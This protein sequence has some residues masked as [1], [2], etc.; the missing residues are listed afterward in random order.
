[1]RFYKNIVIFTGTIDYY[2]NRLY[3]DSVVSRGVEKFFRHPD[4]IFEALELSGKGLCALAQQGEA[5]LYH[6]ADKANGFLL[7]VFVIA[8]HDHMHQPV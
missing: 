1:M 4:S 6:T 3:N 8:L 2:A 7:A 5:G